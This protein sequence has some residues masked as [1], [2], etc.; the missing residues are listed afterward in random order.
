MRVIPVQECC[1]MCAVVYWVTEPFYKERMR[2]GK[3]FY[4]PN[5]HEQHYTNNEAD[6]FKRAEKRA[7]N[8]AERLEAERRSASAQRGVITRMK[9]KENPDA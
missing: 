9:R 7:K 6:R 5:G 3:S 2:T 1:C 8:L 4:C